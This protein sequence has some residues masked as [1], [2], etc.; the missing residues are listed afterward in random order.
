MTDTPGLEERVA[1]LEATVTMLT[2]KLFERGDITI[3]DARATHGLPPFD[4]KM[5][6]IGDAIKDGCQHIMTGGCPL[7]CFR[8]PCRLEQVS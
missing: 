3:N 6:Q 5:A 4:L 7:D 1:A 8:G 2:R